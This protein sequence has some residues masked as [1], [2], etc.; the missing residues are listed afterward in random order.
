MS[1]LGLPPGDTGT[2]RI[3]DHVVS[4]PEDPYREQ[5]PDV[6]ALRTGMANSQPEKQNAE[7][8]RRIE[9]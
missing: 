1:D 3:T 6:Q 2:K 9:A 5:E 4:G 7:G 8:S